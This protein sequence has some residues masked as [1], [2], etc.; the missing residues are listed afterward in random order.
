MKKHL[1]PI[2]LAILI[3]AAFTASIYVREER[4]F[5]PELRLPGPMKFVDSLEWALYDFKFRSL[6]ATQA[7]KVIVARID[8]ASLSRYGSWPWSRTVY[9]EVLQELYGLGAEVVAF[10]A[11]FSEPEFDA[12]EVRYLF[13][14]HPDGYA[15]SVKSAASLNDAQLET[16]SAELPR[17]GEGVF[18]EGLTNTATV[19]GYIWQAGA[20]CKVEKP[21]ADSSEED[22]QIR[23][24]GRIP[25]RD[26][27]DALSS[28][29]NESYTVK[30]FP[31]LSPES[32][33]QSF[34]ANQCAVA[35]RSVLAAKAA[36]QG[37]FNSIADADGLFRR[38][39]LVFGFAPDKVKEFVSEED[40]EFLNPDWLQ[41]A[42]FFPSLGLK[43][44]L[45][46]LDRMDEGE[47]RPRTGFQVQLERDQDG[48]IGIKG[49]EIQRKDG[50]KHFF[51]TLPDGTVALRFYGSQHVIPYPVGEFSLATTT[52]LATEPY[53]EFRKAYGLD[54]QQPLKDH[55]VIIGP[56]A[57]GVYDLRPNPVQ[58]DAAGVFLHAT[59]AGR[60]L[61]NLEDPAAQP[62][63]MNWAG[64]MPSI[65]LLWFLGL[66]L[67]AS[68]LLLPGLQGTW[69]FALLTATAIGVDAWFF[70]EK[71]TA[72]AGVHVLLS[73]FLVFVVLIAYKYMTEEKDRAFVKSAFE[74]YVSPDL[75]GDILKDPKKLNLGGERREMTV[76]FS[77]V[78]GFTTLSEAMTASELGKF[79]NEYL[80]PMTDVI[81]ENKGTIDKY[82]GDAIM[83]LFGA[84]VKYEGHAKC[85]AMAGLK[86]LEKLEELKKGWA[87]RGLPPIEV[88]IGLNTGDMSVGN[89]GSTRIFSYTVMG[90]AVN[91]GSRLESLTKEYGVRFMV[92]EFTRAQLD[93]GFAVRELDRVKVKG[94]TKPVTIFEVMAHGEAVEKRLLAQKF[95]AALS[96]YY[97]QNFNEAQV[98]FQGLADADATAAIYVRRCELWRE[99]PP[100]SDWDGSWTMKTK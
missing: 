2:L 55:I 22:R 54:E 25:V 21:T 75:V 58:A 51:E 62:L 94:K 98:L 88:G 81:Q 63:S 44:V 9:K 6:G 37:F 100:P 78:R 23:S 91:L 10:D 1:T 19:L 42:T 31:L 14:V 72:L 3:F 76:M 70:I 92:S 36:H 67:A 48:R 32:P 56:T 65:F 96:L 40:I 26:F 68:V 52:L 80:S 82:I 35:N 7:K 57:L 93:E 73:L 4:R 53:A 33:Q 61:A 50:R 30:D 18:A 28:L 69:S 66:G 13:D 20:A 24:S 29:I 97:S 27:V 74:K 41:G 12:E 15:S 99:N 71:H 64:S 79:M 59:S 5:S 43:S 60:M 45:A 49:V 87:E 47:L 8:D 46:Y 84:P 89:M 83:A 39:P 85:A 34:R 17:V 90:D 11:V 95:E 16:I 38:M 86:M 77:D